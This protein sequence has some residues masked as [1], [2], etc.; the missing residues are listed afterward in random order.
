M[1]L[2]QLE[3]WQ[4][5]LQQVM[6]HLPHLVTLYLPTTLHLPVTTLSP[7]LLKHMVQIT[8]HSH[9]PGLALVPSPSAIH[10]Q[11]LVTQLPVEH[12]S[13]MQRTAS[14]SF[15]ACFLSQSH[16]CVHTHHEPTHVY[17][18]STIDNNILFCFAWGEFL[19]MPTLN[20]ARG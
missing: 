19:I 9:H 3:Q 7:L 8:V 13:L 5:L 16:L 4:E 12:Y 14:A 6:L 2:H 15:T 1:Q 10:H 18:H 11:T 17:I 20:L